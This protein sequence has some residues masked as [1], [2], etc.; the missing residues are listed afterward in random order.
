MK[1]KQS[2]YRNSLTEKDS[3]QNVHCVVSDSKQ[4]LDGIRILI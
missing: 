3:H 1:K 4:K 2:S